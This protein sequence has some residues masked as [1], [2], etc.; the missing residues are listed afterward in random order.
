MD[1][2]KAKRYGVLKKTTRSSVVLLRR[3]LAGKHSSTPSGSDGSRGLHDGG[4]KNIE[5][6]PYLLLGLVL[7]D[8][9]YR[10]FV[11]STTAGERHRE[12]S[13]FTIW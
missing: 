2:A 1:G 3:V 10:G 9:S 12:D 13:F 4:L 7:E 5:Q 6:R 11:F 8:P